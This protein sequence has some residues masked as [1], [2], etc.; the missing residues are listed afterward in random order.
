MPNQR[1]IPRLLVFGV[2]WMGPL[3]FR[4]H[5]ADLL[6][7]YTLAATSVPEKKLRTIEGEGACSWG[8]R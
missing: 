5:D 4:E 1:L 8:K 7:P 3:G 2:S 6:S